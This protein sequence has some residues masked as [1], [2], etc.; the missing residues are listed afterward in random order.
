MG[1]IILIKGRTCFKGKGS[2]IDLILINR[3]FSF[4]NTQSFQ[5]GLNDH[6]HMV[7]TMLKATFQKS[8]PKQLIYRDF[9]NFDLKSFKMIY[10]KIWLPVT[11]HLMN[12][13]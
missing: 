4:K 9:E 8:E 13:I 11:N 1:Y 7:Y 3:K 6:H 12:L 2:L 10:W 5:T